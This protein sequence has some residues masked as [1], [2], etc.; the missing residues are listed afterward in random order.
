MSDLD[1]LIDAARLGIMDDLK[2]ILRSHPELVRERDETGATALH[3][4]AFRGHC[5]AARLLIAA[6]ADVNATDAQFNATPAGWA[7]EY[8][9]EMGGLLGIELGDFAYAIEKGDADWVARFLQR[10]PALRHACDTRGQP[11]RTLAQDSPNPE[12]QSLFREPP[13]PQG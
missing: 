8:L 4:A 12:I 2:A 6:G 10:F 3:Y 7:I 1:K 13:G 9:R 11:F 5:D